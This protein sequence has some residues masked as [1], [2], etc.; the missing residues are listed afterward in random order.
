MLVYYE[1]VNGTWEEAQKKEK[2][3][4][5]WN[6]AWK[7]RLIQEENQDWLDL[8]QGWNLDIYKD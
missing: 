5:K 1:V 2:Q 7:M 4:K 8:S 6:R 3:L